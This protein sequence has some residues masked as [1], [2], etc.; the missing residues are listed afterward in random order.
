[1]EALLSN[2][3]RAARSSVIRDLLKLVERPG[4]LSLA[5]GLPA[6]ESFPIARMREAANRVLG[7][8]EG[9]ASPLQ[10]G[11]TE[12]IVALREWVAAEANPSADVDDVV[13]TT[14]SQQALDLL[15]HALCDPG[16]AVAIEHP[17][18]LGASQAFDAAGAQLVPI[19][20]DA[21]GL[22]VDE[23][24]A[25]LADGLRPKA[26]Y[27]APNF[28]NPTGA[29]LAL[30]RR[31]RLAALAEQYRFVVIEDDPYREL[32]FAG[33]P[34]PA[35]RSFGSL[36]VTLGSASKVLAPGLRVG[37]MVAPRW[38]VPAVVRLKQARDL[39]TSTM[40]Q[41]MAHDVLGDSEFL[42]GHRVVLAR[43]YAERCRALVAALRTR[44]DGQIELVEPDGGMF[45]WGRVTGVDTTA[46]LPSAVEH[47]VAFVPGSAFY[48]DGG[49]TE[50]VRLSF[51]T[52]VPDQL[53]VAVERL[54]R[55]VAAAS[56]A[57]TAALIEGVN[58]RR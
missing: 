53:D 3:A 22:D 45:V 10:Y 14:G 4:I 50:H 34:V 58:D 36:V 55:A 12:G 23:L 15:A 52:L 54:A 51:A 7:R 56:A 28:Q 49:G 48:L 26:C 2:R 40:S 33:E 44:L 31:Q 5:G 57:P 29:T 35:V 38:L 19:A 37:W 32:R 27:V 24:A 30:A 17:A 42:A 25:R 43:L 41:W 21:A 39:H 9:I 1:M 18:Y 6:P 11:P 16:D 20:A 47:G 8:N 46:L 13:I